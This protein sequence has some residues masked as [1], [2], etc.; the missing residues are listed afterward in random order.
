MIISKLET[1]YINIKD[2]VRHSN[3]KEQ[4]EFFNGEFNKYCI[5]FIYISP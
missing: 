1:I 4:C 5:E 2:C 3:F